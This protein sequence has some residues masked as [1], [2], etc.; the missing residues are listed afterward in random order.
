[1]A[2]GKVIVP[3]LVL[4][5][6]E[7]QAPFY[8]MRKGQRSNQSIPEIKHSCGLTQ[9][10]SAGVECSEGQHSANLDRI[11]KEATWVIKKGSIEI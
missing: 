7:G 5:C 11:G 9:L 1:M 4:A 10:G 3:Y 2:S 6:S 8:R